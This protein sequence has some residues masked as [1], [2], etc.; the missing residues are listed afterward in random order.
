MTCED[1]GAEYQIGDWPFCKGGHGKPSPGTTAPY[2]AHFDLA[3]GRY[4][5]SSA[6]QRRV[7]KEMNVD[8]R[9]PKTGMP[10]CEI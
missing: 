7:M 10:G 1:C 4:I 5:T 8:Y 6:E 9:S 3:L 2:V